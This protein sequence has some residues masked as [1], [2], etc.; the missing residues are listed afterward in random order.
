MLKVLLTIGFLQLLTML[1]QLVRTKALALMLGP[2]MVGAMS[3]IDKLLQVIAQSLSLSLPFAAVRFLPPQWVRDPRAFAA[4]AR[5]MRTILTVLIVA[6]TVIGTAIT[7]AAPAVW[8]EKLLPY[9]DALSVAFLTLPVLALVPFLQNAIAG[10]MQ[11]YQSMVFALLHAVVFTVTGVV[12]VW[13]KGLTGFYLMYAA[14]GLALVWWGAR[15]VEAVPDGVGESPPPDTEPMRLGLPVQIWKFAAAMVSLTFLAPYA[16][17]AVQYKVLTYFGAGTA[18]W[19]Q[20][21]VGVS[22]AV[23]GVLGSAHAVFLTPQVNKEGTPVDRWYRATEF[24]KTLCFL[25]AVTVPPLLLLPQIVVR[26]LYSSAFLPGAAFVVLFVLVEVLTMLSGTYQALIIAHNHLAYHV[27]QSVAAQL[28]LVGVATALIPAHGII[29]AG[30]GA[31]CAPALLYAGTLIFLWRK[32]GLRVPGRQFALTGFV[33]AVLAAAG[34]AGTL[35]PALTWGTIALKLMM[36]GTALGALALFLT[37]EDRR[38]L[39]RMADG[40]RQWLRPASGH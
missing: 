2:E 38:N 18:G 10:R 13:W 31:L 40:V 24:Q 28:L 20:A 19:M 26:L 8:G 6:A 1:V 34:T 27:A 4:L 15:R 11:Q 22:L 33:L 32:H 5:R 9:R 29:G 3:V 17:L 7:F 35:F 30:I 16:S 39:A 23:R 25:V 37:G 21:A 36:Y 12:G 14:L